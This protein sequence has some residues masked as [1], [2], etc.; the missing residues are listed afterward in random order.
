MFVDD[1]AFTLNGKNCVK[2][3]QNIIDKY[4]L[5]HKATRGKIQEEKSFSYC[6]Q[7]EYVDGVKQIQ[8]YESNMTINSNKIKQLE[9]AKSVRAL[10]VY[11]TPSLQQKDQF[12]VMQQKM[13]T[14]IKKS[15]NTEL[16]P[17]QTHVYFNIYILKS[18]FFGRGVI[19]L[20]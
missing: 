7:Q 4:K 12:E 5:L 9:A 20:N 14:S 1:T 6:W 17:Y 2:R 19:E 8:D 11:L 13:V 18:V 15:M 10:G 3:M 16:T